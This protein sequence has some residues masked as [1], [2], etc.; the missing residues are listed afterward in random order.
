MIPKTPPIGDESLHVLICND[1]GIEAPGLLALVEACIETGH[2]VSVVAPNQERSGAGSS[3][4]VHGDITAQAYHGFGSQVSQAWSVS[5]TPGDC[6]KLALFALLKNDR[7]QVLVSGVNR[8]QNTGTCVLYS[9]TLGAALEGALLGIPSLAVSL[10]ILWPDQAEMR[11]GFADEDPLISRHAPREIY[12][13]LIS[14]KEPFSFAAR[15]A[16][17]LLPA[18]ARNPLP[19]GNLLT[20]NVPV[21]SDETT[22]IDV[23]VMGPSYF[24]DEFEELTS[25]ESSGPK[26]SCQIR[27]FRNIGDKLVHARGHGPW[28]DISLREGRIS[29][30]PLTFD[31]TAYSLMAQCQELVEMRSLVPSSPPKN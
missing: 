11:P 24:L 19:W 22:P 2:R 21:G 27:R 23:G 25:L 4:T 6:G 18:Y 3:I 13:Q 20:L 12:S 28:D 30:V 10:G 17:S 1:D 29:L 15:L 14:S 9:G 26:V 5:G 8:G 16:V 7:P 31:R